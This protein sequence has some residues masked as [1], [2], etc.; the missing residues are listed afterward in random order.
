MKNTWE[1]LKKLGAGIIVL[2][3]VLMMA[4]TFSSQPMDEIIALISGSSKAGQFNNEPIS[5]KDYS[6]VYNECENQ[7]RRFGLTEIPPVFLQNCIMQNILSLYVK[8]V[9][10][11]ELGLNV[12]REFIENE[13]LNYVKEIYKMQKRNSLA[14][15]QIPIEE[16]YQRELGALPL[17]T[18]ISLTKAN[19]V[20]NFLG[21]PINTSDNDWNVTQS[22]AKNEIQ[23]E[24]SL[25]AFTNQELL[26]QI[27]V[28]V[29]REEIQNQY[30]KEKQEFLSKEE[31]K[32]KE[33]PSLNERIKFIEESI[34]NEKKRL[35]LSKIKD[36]LNKLNNE[37]MY[38]FN[39]ITNIVN[40]QPSKIQISLKQLQDGVVINNK[41]VQLLHK[42]F[43]NAVMN[44]NNNA[45]IG[46]IQDKE[47]TVYVK[48]LNIKKNNLNTNVQNVDLNKEEMEKRLTYNFYEYILEQYKKRGKFQLYNLI[49][50]DKKNN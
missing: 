29:S 13:I 10:A 42:E 15:D 22:I 49:E 23:L 36:E 40:I 39:K 1:I 19:L 33:Y 41:R 25:I 31:N 26:N 2:L 7:F 18:R 48:L 5:L 27:N 16:L 3:L 50:N 24:V 38:D 8:P 21:T 4:I 43:L 9:I 35:E 37:T 34:K 47:N 45:I 17:K 30:E 44:N 6:F 28:N 46:P 12:S 32:N 20:D 14:D 11:D